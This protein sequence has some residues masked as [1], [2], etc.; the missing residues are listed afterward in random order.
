M[1]TGTARTGK[2]APAPCPTAS[3]LGTEER[4]RAQYAAIAESAMNKDMRAIAKTLK[5]LEGQLDE[6]LGKYD[7]CTL[8]LLLMKR[9][10]MDRD[11]ELHWSIEERADRWL[12]DVMGLHYFVETMRSIIAGEVWG[13]EEEEDEPAPKSR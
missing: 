8:D 3:P 9:G 2:P 11:E 4:K 5:A 1:N 12:R 6:F 10:L 7:S 13:G